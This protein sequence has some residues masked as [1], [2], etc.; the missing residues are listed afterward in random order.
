[1]KE[2]AKAPNL[3]RSAERQPRVPQQNSSRNL[4]D[5]VLIPVAASISGYTENAIRLKLKRGIWPYGI[6]W[7]H[8]PDR[9]VVIHLPSVAAWMGSNHG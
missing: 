8:G 1:M 5:W 6:F 3:G 7:R 2:A 4:F 9:R